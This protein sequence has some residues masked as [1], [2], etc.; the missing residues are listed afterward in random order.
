MTDVYVPKRLDRGPEHSRTRAAKIG[1]Y[2]GGIVLGNIIGV[3]LIDATSYALDSQPGPAPEQNQ[4]VDAVASTLLGGTFSVECED[5]SKVAV[6]G[7]DR[8]RLEGYVDAGKYMVPL[9]TIRLPSQREHLDLDVC[10]QIGAIALDP[11]TSSQKSLPSLSYEQVV[12]LTIA[13]HERVHTHGDLDEAHTE[14]VAL[15]ETAGALV[16]KGYNVTHDTSMARAVMSYVAATPPI[17]HSTKCRVGGEWDS[18]ATDPQM[19]HVWLP[20]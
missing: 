20:K 11:S 5:L 2:V 16:A 17:Y 10:G 8:L 12:A 15:Q 9:T 19:S 14:C 6:S 7:G 3:G 13:A 1:T 18:S 4:R